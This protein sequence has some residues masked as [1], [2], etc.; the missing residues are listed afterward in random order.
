MYR[1]ALWHPALVTHIFSVCTPYLPPSRGPFIETEALVRDYIPQFAYQ[2]HLA[3]PEVEARIQT[4][5][6]MRQFLTA[7]YG[8][9][10]PAGEVGFDV[11][12]GV[13]FDNLPKLAKSPLLKDDE[14]EYYVDQYSRTGL[15]G[16]RENPLSAFSPGTLPAREQG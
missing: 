8:G 4:R 3:G 6:D 10:G 14:L 15:H 1:V 13:L 12:K 9:R 2:L 5:D 16:P 7:T 11:S